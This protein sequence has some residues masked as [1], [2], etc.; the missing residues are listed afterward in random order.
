MT[1]ATP[2]TR[3]NVYTRLSYDLTP[4]TEVFM[5]VNWSQVGTSNIPESGHVAERA[6]RASAATRTRATRPRRSATRRSPRPPCTNNPGQIL[7]APGIQCGNAAGGANA[8]LPASVQAAC[9]ANNITSFSFG[10]LYY[11]LGPQKVYTQRDNRRYVGGADGIF[12]LFDTKWNWQGYYQHGENDT[13]IHV[14]GIALKPYMYAAI[15]SVQVRR[16]RNATTRPMPRWHPARHHRLPQ[17]HA[18]SRKAACPSIPL[19]RRPARPRR[20]GS[21][22]A[23]NWGPGP[24]QISHQMQ[25][26]FD[27]S[28]SGAPIQDWAGPVSVAFGGAWRQEAYDVRGDGAGNGTIGGAGGAPGSPCNDPLLN[29]LQRHQL[30]CRQL[31][32][33]PG[34]LSRDGR[35]RGIQRAR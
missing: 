15:D 28:I 24:I 13:N 27:F 7:Q 35:L 16:R 30:V 29:C 5:T 31:P 23:S 10:S 19:A 18:P 8:F 26:V 1:L 32:Q 34:Q 21:M 22:A 6:A 12:D 20:T 4:D 33:R 2:L 17:H 9:I 25:D 11:G 14:R 3:G